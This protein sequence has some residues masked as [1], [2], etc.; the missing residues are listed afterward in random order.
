MTA[1]KVKNGSGKSRWHVDFVFRHPDGRKAR[2]R[3]I[4]PIQTKLGAEDYER[5]LRQEMLNPSP[6]KKEYP[7]LERFIEDQWWNTYPAAARNRPATL[8]EKRKHIDKHIVPLLGR[9]PLNEID[10]RKVDAFYAR[11]TEKELAP[12]SCKTSAGR[13][14]RSSSPP[15]SGKS[16]TRCRVSPRSS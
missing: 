3:E 10:K 11:L 12:K 13:C 6:I 8:R 2:V 7:T 14:T 5:K 4:S 1:R 15:S 16:S 9:V